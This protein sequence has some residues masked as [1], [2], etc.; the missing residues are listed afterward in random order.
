MDLR[1]RSVCATV[2][3]VSWGL[4]DIQPRD[5]TQ[6]PRGSSIS[7]TGQ[8]LPFYVILALVRRNL[9]CGSAFIFC[10]SGSSFFFNAD[11]GPAVF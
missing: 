3:S 7:T 9:S 6:I 8:P 4:S 1:S 10:G 11:P 5:P 2:A